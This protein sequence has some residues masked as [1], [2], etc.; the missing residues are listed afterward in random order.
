M[1]NIQ[2]NRQEILDTVDTF[3]FNI[4]NVSRE[5]GREN[6]FPAIVFRCMEDLPL[7]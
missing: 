5:I 3:E 2:D 6:T 1:M 4:L 7:E